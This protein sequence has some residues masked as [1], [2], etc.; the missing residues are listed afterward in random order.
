MEVT[1]TSETDFS[2]SVTYNGKSYSGT[3]TLTNNKDIRITSRVE[4]VQAIL[5]GILIS[6]TTVSGSIFIVEGDQPNKIGTW[7][8]MK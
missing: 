8:A 3:G 4:G 2:V 7:E 5:T 1:K 6:D